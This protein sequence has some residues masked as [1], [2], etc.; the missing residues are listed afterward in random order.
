MLQLL[1]P[2][3]LLPQSPEERDSERSAP[4]LPQPLLAPLKCSSSLV[5]SG[6]T[7]SGAESWLY[8]L[9]RCVPLSKL[10]NISGLKF[11]ICKMKN[12][13]NTTYLVVLWI[14]MYTHVVYDRTVQKVIK[15]Y[16]C[17]CCCFYKTW[18][19]RPRVRV[20]STQGHMVS[21]TEWMSGSLLALK[22]L[23]LSSFCFCPS[24]QPH[25]L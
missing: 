11:H 24:R 7:L 18:K 19:R 2:L 12:G 4:P 16:I 17:V 10:L 9:L 14:Y 21:V 13:K 3:H 6:A 8:S 20:G 15:C 5:A 1:P 22:F 23:S 25:G